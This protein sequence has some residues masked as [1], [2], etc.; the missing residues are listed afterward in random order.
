MPENGDKQRSEPPSSDEY[1]RLKDEADGLRE[2]SLSDQSRRAVKR[3]RVQAGMHSY[4]RYT[5]IG[6]QFVLVVILGVAGGYGLDVL[7]GTTPW[8]LLVGAILGSVGAMVW[9]VRT[10]LRMENKTKDRA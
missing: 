5:G 7:F 10:V 6:M 3:Q 9:V 2:T 4:V 8:L 1:A